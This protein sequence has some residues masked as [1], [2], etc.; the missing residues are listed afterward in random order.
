M[1]GLKS[2]YID[3]TGTVLAYPTLYIMLTLS[4]FFFRHVIKAIDE[5][6]DRTEAQRIKT[7]P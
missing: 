1:V 3:N 6:R 4:H 7:M 2:R 5:L